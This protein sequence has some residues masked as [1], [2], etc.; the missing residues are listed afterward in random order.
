M[1]N[2]RGRRYPVDF[3]RMAVERF[4]NCEIIE[5]LAKEVG[6]PRQALYR[7]FGESEREEVGEEW[8]EPSSETT[9]TVTIAEKS[10]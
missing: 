9:A 4:K 1:A 7:W 10:A 3:R 6:V 8:S 2:G 5:W